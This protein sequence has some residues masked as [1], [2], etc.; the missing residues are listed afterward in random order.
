M[1]GGCR[2]NRARRS[3]YSATSVTPPGAVPVALTFSDG[4]WNIDPEARYQTQSLLDAAWPDSTSPYVFT[5]T[6]AGGGAGHHRISLFSTART[7]RP[8]CISV[9]FGVAQA[10]DPGSDFTLNWDAFASA[11]AD[12]FIILHVASEAG[13]VVE[14]PPIGVS[15]YLDGT[16][17]SYIIP[18]GT[19]TSGTRYRCEL[20]FYKTS[21]VNSTEVPNAIGRAFHT[22]STE[23]DLHATPVITQQPLNHTMHPGQRL[24]L[25]VSAVGTGDLTY[26]W[27]KGGTT[28]PGETDPVLSLASVATE[29][30]GA[31]EVDVT[32]S[33]GT[34]TS[35]VANL[36]INPAA[37]SR[38]TNL[39][40]RSLVLTGTSI[41]IPGFAISGPGTKRILLRAVG[42]TL[43]DYGVTGFLEDPQISLVGSSVA[44]PINDNW[45]DAVDVPAI[46]QASQLV[47]AFD[48]PDGSKDA[49]LLVDLPQ[50]QY[51][52]QISGVA[53]AT[54]V[55]LAEVYDADDASNQATL[56]NISNRGYVGVGGDI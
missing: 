53:D 35:S 43:T 5:L 42:P 47:S 51:S 4:S 49:V 36:N 46:Q 19:L 16:V 52:L 29:D 25:T 54:G 55:A 56:V 10:I 39:S 44:N 32:D 9:N 41:M 27:K 24:L 6:P 17:T 37:S 8:P 34:V 45:N 15:G 22:T 28:L 11:T 38:I 26:Q 31:Y 30:A 12:D 1:D 7:T 48:L 50:G 23:F 3:E 13:T 33:T 20:G 2:R 18:A 40:N 14:T 21:N